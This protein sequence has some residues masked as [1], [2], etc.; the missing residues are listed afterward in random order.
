MEKEY[1]VDFEVYDCDDNC[2]QGIFNEK[3]VI[4]EVKEILTSRYAD[5]LKWFIINENNNGIKE[6]Y[7]SKNL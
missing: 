3:T 6:I 7:N 5:K 1:I 4:N 2:I